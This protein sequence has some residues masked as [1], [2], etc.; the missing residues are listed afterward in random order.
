[1]KRLISLFV[2]ITFVMS[3][4]APVFAAD[5]PKPVDKLVKGT[6]EVVTSPKAALDHT[7][8]SIDSADYMAIGLFKGLLES[9]F[10][11]VKKAGHGAIDIATFPIE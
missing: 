5:L 9:P 1:M 11:V 2:V 10:H 3:I 6:T 4:A 8:A 7:K